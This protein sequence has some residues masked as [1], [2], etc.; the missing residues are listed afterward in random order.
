[1]R[2]LIWSRQTLYFDKQYLFSKMG[3]EKN[4][5]SIYHKNI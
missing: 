1:M 3:P 5:Y 4:V 2:Q